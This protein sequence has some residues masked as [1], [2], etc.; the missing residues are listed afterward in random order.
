MFFFFF[1]FFFQTAFCVPVR[2]AFVCHVSDYFCLTFDRISSGGLL[3]CIV[4]EVPLTLINGFYAD[5]GLYFQYN[6]SHTIPGISGCGNAY[7]FL[8][9][10]R[11]DDGR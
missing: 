5:I 4:L 7:R 6:I 3:L 2:S 11:Q 10:V 1:F 8:W 9:K